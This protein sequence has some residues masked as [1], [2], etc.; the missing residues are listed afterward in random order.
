[1]RSFMCELLR[2]ASGVSRKQGSKRF[3]P[4]IS[5]FFFFFIQIFKYFNYVEAQCCILLS[6]DI[7]SCIC[8]RKCLVYLL[9]VK[10]IYIQKNLP[11]II[12]PV[13][14]A[15]SHPLRMYLFVSLILVIKGLHRIFIIKESLRFKFYLQFSN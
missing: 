10:C 4:D 8:M 1:M 13:I 11:A 9:S 14:A 2:S 3:F 15:L 6:G 12:L 5:D 7:S